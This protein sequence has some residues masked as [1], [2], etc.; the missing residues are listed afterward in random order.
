MRTLF[1]IEAIGY[2]GYEGAYSTL[3]QTKAH[4]IM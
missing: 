3:D 1:N 4:V 2:E